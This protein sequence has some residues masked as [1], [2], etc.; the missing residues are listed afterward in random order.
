MYI[1]YIS[2]YVLVFSKQRAITKYGVHEVEATDPTITN[3]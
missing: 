1:V 3:M 2:F